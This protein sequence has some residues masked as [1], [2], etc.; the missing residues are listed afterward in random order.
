MGIYAL[1]LHFQSLMLGML[2]SPL[3]LQPSINA[4][5]HC[6]HASSS[7]LS[8][9]ENITIEFDSSRPI[10]TINQI[11]P[12]A[13]HQCSREQRRPFIEIDMSR[14]K[15]L[16]CLL[17]SAFLQAFNQSSILIVAPVMVMIHRIMNS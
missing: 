11:M 14:P 15:C 1:D 8:A 10:S 2:P 12:V 16:G 7:T 13:L 5:Q 17:I 4:S 9:T 6:N 3:H